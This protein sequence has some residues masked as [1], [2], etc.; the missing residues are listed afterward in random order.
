MKLAQRTN[1][2]DCKMSALP[3]LGGKNNGKYVS[4]IEI[5]SLNLIKCNFIGVLGVIQ[6]LVN[7]FFEPYVIVFEPYIIIV[8]PLYPNVIRI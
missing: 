7:Y 1:Q 3:A 4:R 2:Y 5:Q 6:Y 8:E